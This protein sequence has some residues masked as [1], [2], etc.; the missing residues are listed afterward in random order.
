MSLPLDKAPTFTIK[1]GDQKIRKNRQVFNKIAQKVAETKKAKIS[2]TKLNLKAKDIYN[3]P[4]LK[5]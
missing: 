1:Q 3:K 5:P 2:T 4:L